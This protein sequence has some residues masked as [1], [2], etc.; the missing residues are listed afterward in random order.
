M[1]GVWPAAHDFLK[2]EHDWVAEFIRSAPQT[3]EVRRSI[4]LLA[5][6]LAFAKNWSGPI[7]MLEIGA[8]AGLN[9]NWDRFAYRTARWSWGEAS[10]VVIDTDWSGPSPPIDA[11][12]I[13]RHRAACDLNP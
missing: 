7:D 8:S 2:R 4:A 13:V 10:P 3:N 6:F 5:G 9:V 11:H 1:D 12:P